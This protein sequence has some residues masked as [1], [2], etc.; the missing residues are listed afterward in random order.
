MAK[1]LKSELRI[2]LIDDAFKLI[3]AQLVVRCKECKLA[4]PDGQATGLSSTYV[5]CKKHLEYVTK[6]DYCS[7]AERSTQNEK[8]TS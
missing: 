3:E 4:E 1:N 6:E 7:W 8:K 2:A 5:W